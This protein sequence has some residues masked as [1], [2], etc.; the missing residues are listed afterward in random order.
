MKAS[1]KNTTV[2]FFL[3]VSQTQ[4]SIKINCDTKFTFTSQNESKHAM[5][6]VMYVVNLLEINCL[7]CKNKK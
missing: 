2:F 4:T 3:Y 7:N 5:I 1:N 6:T